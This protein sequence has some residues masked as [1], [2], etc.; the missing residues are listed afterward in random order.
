[1]IEIRIIR[2]IELVLQVEKGDVGKLD[3]GSD[4]QFFYTLNPKTFKDIV[5]VSVG[6]LPLLPLTPPSDPSEALLPSEGT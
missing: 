4:V 5:A 1:M 3:I 6:S 2:C